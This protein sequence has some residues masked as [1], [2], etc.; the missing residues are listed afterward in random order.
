MKEK[1][2][3]VQQLLKTKGYPIGN[4]DGVLGTKTLSALDQINPQYASWKGTRKL[5]AFIQSLCK[6]KA[7]EVGEIDGLWGTQTSFAYSILK[8]EQLHE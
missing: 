5:V 1:I 2:I 4:V 6:Q 3:F 8:Y 7:I